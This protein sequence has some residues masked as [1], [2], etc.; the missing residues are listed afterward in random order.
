VCNGK[1]ADW[2]EFVQIHDQLIDLDTLF[3]LFDIFRDV[4]YAQDD[5]G[6]NSGIFPNDFRQL[7]ILTPGSLQLSRSSMRIAG[8]VGRLANRARKGS[9][10]G[11]SG[12]EILG[13]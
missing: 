6:R 10:P 13:L 9:F 3:Q 12:T 7:R 2:I 8:G 4:A 1:R 5:L 11:K